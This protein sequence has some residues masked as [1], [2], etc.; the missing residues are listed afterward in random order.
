MLLAAAAV[1][2]AQHGLPGTRVHQIV[3]RAGV[4][5]RMIYH[6]FGSKEGLYRAVLEDQWLGGDGSWEAALTEAQ[7]LGPRE[8]LRLVLG[9]LFERMLEERPLVLRLGLQDALNDWDGVPR[10]SMRQVPEGL[11]DLYLRGQREGVFRADREFDLFYLS[12]LGVLTGITVIGPRFAD[13]R[14]RS[15]GDPAYVAGL[16]DRALD[17]VLDGVAVR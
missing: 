13:V 1:E 12:A 17:L 2:F 11:R 8:G 7:E 9:R 16:R 14:E 5:E 15:A 6:H 3:R 10:A 4:N